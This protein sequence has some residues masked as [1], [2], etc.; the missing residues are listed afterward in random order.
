MIGGAHSIHVGPAGVWSLADGMARVLARYLA[1]VAPDQA[2]AV[3]SANAPDT[4]SPLL[5]P[6]RGQIAVRVAGEW[7]WSA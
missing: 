2:G 7:L 1:S 4:P 6:L 5:A 3:R